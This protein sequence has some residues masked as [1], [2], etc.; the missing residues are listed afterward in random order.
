M[1]RLLT[2][3]LIAACAATVSAQD[4]ESLNGSVPGDRRLTF[5]YEIDF[6]A[7]AQAWTLNVSLT[8]G[9]SPGLAV[10]LIDVDALASS[11]SPTPT[12]IDSH[13][14]TAP[15]TASATLNGSY[16]GVHCFAVE[17]ET[18]QGTA[19]SD[20]SGSLT[21][22]AGTITFKL[23]DQ[24]VKTAT[25]L[26]L[27]VGKFAFWDGAVPQNTT[28]AQS[29]ELDFGPT[30]HTEFI[31]LEG[32]GTNIVKIEFID[33]TGGSATILATFSNPTAGEFAAVPLTHSGK[34]TLRI[35]VQAEMLT[36]GSAVWSIT[37]PCSVSLSL[38]GIPGSGGDNDKCSTGQGSGS[39]LLLLG[40][41]AAIAL[42]LRLGRRTANYQQP[43]PRHPQTNW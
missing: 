10:N 5:L 38:V 18:A 40:A 3:V 20:Y 2:L 23:Q 19:A 1:A 27:A 9:A 24:F 12:A 39:W 16:A 21:V 31:R 33:T 36:A 17:I 30:S 22:N 28:L 8:T 26:K 41:L 42:A 29:L 11:A 35:N 43:M 34:A 13:V 7:S 25:G 6:G 14:I 15:G 37:A 32:I 4:T